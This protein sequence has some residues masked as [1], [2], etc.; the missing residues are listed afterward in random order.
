MLIY[1]DRLFWLITVVLVHAILFQQ[2]AGAY[3]KPIGTDSE[4]DGPYAIYNSVCC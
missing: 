4:R 2:G 1:C 3:L